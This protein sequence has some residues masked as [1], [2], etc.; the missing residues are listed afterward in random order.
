MK[1]LEVGDKV[2]TGTKPDAYEPVYAFGHLHP[3]K[4]ITFH[5]IYTEGAVHPL[6]LTGDHLVFVHGK[7][8]PIRADCIKVND[9]LRN[10]NEKQGARVVKVSSVQKSGLYAPL[11]PCGRIM[12]D[13][14]QTSAYISLQQHAMEFVEM[15]SPLFSTILPYHTYVHVGLSPFRFVCTKVSSPLCTQY[16]KDG[17]P[18]YAALA[19]RA[20]TWLHNQNSLVEVAAFLVLLFLTCAAFVLEYLFTYPTFLWLVV[21]VPLF[22]MI[23]KRRYSLKIK[24]A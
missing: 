19:M 21:V 9:V 4:I 23:I 10:E 22:V 8:N 3:T 1:D 20:N 11:T 16:D 7:T 18:Y 2:W 5:Q 12:V 14:I 17:V 6:E 13:G 15:K 24:K